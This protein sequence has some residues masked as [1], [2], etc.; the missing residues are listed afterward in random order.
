MQELEYRHVV[1][2]FLQFR[3]KVLLL[4][5][6]GKVGTYRSRWAAVSGYLGENEEPLQ[7]ARIE[8]HEEVGLTSEQLDF[9]RSGEVLRAFDE[10]T[11]VVWI[12]HPFLFEV[13]ERKDRLDWEHSEIK[14]VEPRELARYETV[15]KLRETYDRVRW[16]LRDPSPSLSSA[17]ERIEDIAQ[18][19]VH[20]ASILGRS[21]IELIREVAVVSDASSPDELFRDIFLVTMK[22]RTAQP[23][24]ATIRNVSGKLLHRIDQQ[25][26]SLAQVEEFRGRLVALAED[27]LAEAEAAAED[28]ARNSVAVLPSEGWLLTHSY[29]SVL[30][31]AVGLGIK[32]G[33]K[34]RAYVTES[35]PGLEGRAL[36]KDLL[37]LG[38]SVKL[39]A[40]SAVASVMPNVDAVLVGA[41][42]VLAD[43]CVINKVGTKQIA[44]L[45]KENQV[46]FYAACETAKFSTADFLGEPL[47]VSEIFDV[48]SSDYVSK[49]ITEVGPVD[50]KEVKHHVRRMLREFYA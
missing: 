46:S 24:M 20:G 26:I 29:S 45:A 1:T 9:V 6:S 17:L 8:I 31:R 21:S 13:N 50:P 34:F 15:P 16:D 36:A 48:T 39:I 49:I 47:E 7:R 27:A 44:T 12:V 30:R 28:A 38:V 42:S 18:N 5:R 4:R 33:R 3:G 19:R 10:Q 22:L 35:Y 43:G 32:A 25:R 41:D 23:G 11:N 37:S 40:D 2:S 14:W